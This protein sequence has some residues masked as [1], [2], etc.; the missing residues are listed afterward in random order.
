MTT[1]CFGKH[2]RSVSQILEV[3]DIGHLIVLDILNVK[4]KTHEKITKGKTVYQ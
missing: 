2:N 3:T 4:D 1:C